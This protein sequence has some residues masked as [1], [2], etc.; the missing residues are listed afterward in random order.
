MD[1]SFRD[2]L[3]DRLRI[4]ICFILDLTPH[5]K[6]RALVLEIKPFVL[7]SLLLLQYPESLEMTKNIYF[8]GRIG[9]SCPIASNVK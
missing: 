3:P 7:I 8:H 6:E 2:E 4:L 1:F 5:R 9:M